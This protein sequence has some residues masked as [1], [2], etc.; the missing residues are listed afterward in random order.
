MRCDSQR[1][2][3]SHPLRSG[4]ATRTRFVKIS[5]RRLVK[6]PRPPTDS[7]WYPARGRAF[8][9][10]PGG[11]VHYS[12]KLRAKA[13][14]WEAK[15]A[16]M[17]IRRI[18]AAGV[19]LDFVNGPPAPFVTQP[20]MV[21][22]GDVEFVLSDI[23]KGFQSGAYTDLVDSRFVSQAFVNRQG[24]GSTL[25]RRLV[26][27]L[28]WVNAHC[29]AASCR[30]ETA[31]DLGAVVQRGDWLFSSDIE[32]AYHAVQVHK[33]HRRY[34]S[35]HLALPAV[36]LLDGRRQRIPT[37]PGGRW[38]KDGGQDVQLVAASCSA[39]PFGWRGSPLTWTKLMRVWVAFIRS[40]GI[41]CLILLDDLCYAVSG[42]K[43]NACRARSLV[44]RAFDA[45]GLVRQ[46]AKGQW[47]VS[48]RLDDH[49]GFCID[50]MAGTISVPARRCNA[51]R[52]LGHQIL[53]QA[54]TKLR[55]VDSKLLQKFAGTAVSTTLAVFS[56]R[57][58]LR[59][60]YDCMELTR[61]QSRLSR[62]ALSD[63]EWW[64]TLGPES[65][66]NGAP[67]WRPPTTATLWADASG[68]V[69]FGAVLENQNTQ[70]APMHG[71]WSTEEEQLII[72]HKELRAVGIALRRWR[73]ELYDKD[74]LVFEDNL[75]V[76]SLLSKG[77]SRSPTLMRE[78]R[79]IW[80]F[81]LDNKMRLQVRYV[82]SEDN[83]SD[84][85][86]RW[87][88]RS[89]W[90]LHPETA[91]P[92]LRRVTPT[93]DP[94]ACSRSWVVRRFCSQFVE[95]GSLALDGFSVPWGGGERV[96]LSPP[97][98][99]L[100]RVLAK[101]K[102]DRAQGILILPLWRSQVWFPLALD[103]NATWCLLPAPR[104]CVVPLHSGVVEPFV[105]KA[106]RLCALIF[107]ETRISSSVGSSFV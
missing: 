33:H 69:G 15:G 77:T 63:V 52:A 32:K 10:P 22:A 99:L 49:L 62:Q 46:I 100:P 95:D 57:F 1:C 40:L 61:A 88:D 42:S 21:E 75:N 19:K 66:A 104:H 73:K 82:K 4:V 94:F 58:H 26:H 86:S 43:A 67:L 96:W 97:W 5:C 101:I 14:W 25:K 50:S 39:M 11:G 12:S 76:C 47:E 7:K 98:R 41:R 102:E 89:A 30:F 84:Y 31:A 2:D 85:W 70:P 71:Y 72:A 60:V 81:M 106:V 38:I 80:A 3:N 20:I 59:A 29:R 35:F 64:V 44:Q 8:M 45:S 107:D 28:R 105:N 6:R 36:A 79:Q 65:P 90:M 78:L 87:K 53:D 34:L 68:E 74:I 91:A 27:N 24:A 9:A 51:I 83:I 13:A 16:P 93:L 18:I 103:L 17:K 23:S 37:L 55:L 56:A 54:R 48:H 92:L